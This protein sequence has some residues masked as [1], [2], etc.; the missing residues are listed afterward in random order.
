MRFHGAWILGV[1]GLGVVATDA[2]AQP[3]PLRLDVAVTDPPEIPHAKLRAA[4]P[5]AAAKVKEILKA[6]PRVRP[7]TSALTAA[8]KIKDRSA[9]KLE[10]DKLSPQIRAVRADAVAKSGLDA[11]ALEQGLKSV[12]AVSSFRAAKTA[13]PAGA[14][15]GTAS[16]SSFPK[17]YSLKQRCPDTG[18]RV[19]FDGATAKVRASSTPF[20]DDCWVIQGGRTGSVQVPKGASRMVIDIRANVDLDITGIHF[21]T[22]AEV[23]GSFGVRISSPKGVKLSTM[24]IAGKTVPI[25]AVRNTLVTVH[26]RSVGLSPIPVSTDSFADELQEGDAYSSTMFQLPT[27][28]DLGELEVTLLTTAEVDADLT[29]M[30]SANNDITPRSLN[31]KFYK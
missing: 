2:N 14:L 19:D 10:L 24:Q 16:V 8:L 28:A 17:P 6:D 30:A 7:L 13:P 31:I 26:T 21:G 29:G 4:L 25:S 5:P 1:L 11:A 22:F 20:D 18:D 3:A 9:R 23:W 12:S 27:D 15:L